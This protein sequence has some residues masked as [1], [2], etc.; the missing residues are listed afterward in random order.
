[1]NRINGVQ[2]ITRPKGRK[3]NAPEDPHP[4]WH[5]YHGG[6]IELPPPLRLVKGILTIACSDKEAKT[7]NDKGQKRA[8]A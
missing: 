5:T 7:E 3:F 8:Y 2:K 6:L 4:W 1:L